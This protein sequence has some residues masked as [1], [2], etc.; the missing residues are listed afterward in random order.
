MFNSTEEKMI[1]RELGVHGRL[2]QAPKIVLINQPFMN[3]CWIKLN[4]DGTTNGSPGLASCGG[5]F[6]TSCCLV[7]GCFAIIARNVFAFED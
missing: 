1:L 7:K 3:T 6:R 5:V 4:T 2:G